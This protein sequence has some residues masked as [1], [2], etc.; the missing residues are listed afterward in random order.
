MPTKRSRESNRST[1][2]TAAASDDGSLDNVLREFKTKRLTAGSATTFTIAAL[3]LSALPAYAFVTI[4]ELFIR[5]FLIG[6]VG[7]TL[8]SAVCLY[9][10]Y[11]NIADTTNAKLSN[12]R[13]FAPR[14]LGPGAAK[15]SSDDLANM[16]DR[17]TRRESVVWSLMYNNLVYLLIFSFLAFYMLRETTPQVNYPLSVCSAALLVWQFSQHV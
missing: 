1:D 5:D 4:Q 7:V 9:L 12:A 14:K 17:M 15:W 6:Y 8:A 13:K 10:A 16:I 3:V 2:L 11:K